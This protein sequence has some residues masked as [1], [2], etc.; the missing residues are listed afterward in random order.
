MAPVTQV[1]SILKPTLPLSPLKDIP[2]HRPRTQLRGKP[3]SA[4]PQPVSI[5]QPPP[6]QPLSQPAA[7]VP[8]RTEEEQQKRA[9]VLA[10]RAARRQSLGNRRVSFAPEATLHTW[11][12]VDYYRGDGESTTGSSTPASNRRSSN[13]SSIA[14]TP[15][16]PTPTPAERDAALSDEEE[17]GLPE[18]PQN[19][20]KK[21]RRA[22]KTPPMNFNNPDDKFMS[23]SPIS[24]PGEG[25]DSAFDEQDGDSGSN[26]DS[27]D[28]DEDA[29]AG[30]RSFVSA[31]ETTMGERDMTLSRMEMDMSDEDETS[32]TNIQPMFKKPMQWR[33]EGE[34]TEAVS[35]P[36]AALEPEISEPVENND[37]EEEMTMDVTRAVGGLISASDPPQ[38]SF[39]PKTPQ[40]DDDD[41]ELTMEM[42]RPLGGL[43]TNRPPPQLQQYEDDDSMDFTR[44]VGGI[45]NNVMNVQRKQEPEESEEMEEMDMTMDMDVTRP[46]GGILSNFANKI[47]QSVGFGMPQRQPQKQRHEE[48]DADMTMDMDITRAIGGIV[49]GQN[50]PQP[51][52][53]TPSTT[54]EHD[55]NEDMTMEFTSVLGGI[56]SQGQDRNGGSGLL[57][58]RDNWGREQAQKQSE[59]DQQ[60][61]EEMDMDMTM[62]VGGILSGTRQEAPESVA[63]LTLQ[64]AASEPEAVSYP[65]LHV[66]EEKTAVKEMGDE[67]PMDMIVNFGQ[68]L[69]ERPVATVEPTGAPMLEAAAP[70]EVKEEVKRDVALVKSEVP[71]PKVKR[72]ARRSS[73][74]SAT[75]TPRV[76]RGA[77][78]KSL[79]IQQKQ[80]VSESTTIK[81]P[82]QQP[83]PPAPAPVEDKTPE[84]K[85]PNPPKR[86][87]RS[88]A[89]PKAKPA[90]PKSK[91]PTPKA[92]ST[93]PKA[94]EVLAKAKAETPKEPAPKPSSAHVLETPHPSEQF[95]PIVLAGNLKPP[96]FQTPTPKTKVH[97]AT[98]STPKRAT[99]SSV[100]DIKTP[101]RGIGLDK[102]GFGSPAIAS[103][104]SGRKP[105]NQDAMQFSPVA[106]PSALFAAARLDTENRERVVNEQKRRR[107][108]EEKSMDLRSR[109]Q[110]LTPRKQGGR[111]SLAL[112][113][114]IPGKRPLESALESVSKRRK[115]M[116]GAS[117]IVEVAD[118]PRPTRK[119]GVSRPFAPLPS[120]AKKTP[121]KTS[122]RTPKASTPVKSPVQQP[123]EAHTASPPVA[124]PADS[125]PLARIA[126]SFGEEAGEPMEQD[127]EDTGQFTISLQDFLQ[128]IDISFLEL[129]ATKRHHTAFISS[130]NAD[131]KESTLAERIK[132]NVCTAPMLELFMHSCR[133]LEKHIA[134]GR[135]LIEQIEEMTRGETPLLFKEYLD[136]PADVKQV[137]DA[138]F[139]NVKTNARLQAKREWYS[140]RKMLLDGVEKPLKEKLSGLLDDERIVEEYKT[141]LGPLLP[142]IKQ[143]WEKAKD[144]LQKLEE[145][146][147][148]IDM[149]DQD[150]LMA[151]RSELRSITGKIESARAQTLKKRQQTEKINVDIEAKEVK[152]AELIASI[153]EAERIKE[154]NRGWSENEVRTWK[155]RCE[156][157]ERSSGWSISC[158]LPDGRLEMLF[159]REVKLI[160][161]P[162]GKAAP[163]V[164]YVPP[165]SQRPSDCRPMAALETEF[166]ISGLNGVLSKERN[167]K[168]I[169]Q[170]IGSYWKDAQEI[171]IN[172]RRLRLQHHTQVR[173]ADDGNLHVR[174][175]ILVQEL[176][177][178]ME[179]WFVVGK[180][181]L[182]SQGAGVRVVYGAISQQ[183]VQDTLS[184]WSG[185]W[186]EGVSEVVERCLEG[187]RRGGVSLG[188]KG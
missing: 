129:T 175:T 73:G 181:S 27:T 80:P 31:G 90:T 81:T 121:R 39:S 19:A 58:S 103:K 62:A 78:R 48:D 33:F 113:S 30:D 108:E 64:K 156:E 168:A 127:E 8:L 139:K 135:G 24:S 110:L 114:L 76:T 154:M 165:V 21:N 66:I 79:E 65:S 6:P 123:Q 115:S 146:K 148:R 106:L 96:I 32:I 18:T 130:D 50:Q 164:E 157:I 104:L 180:E 71:A 171:D 52:S 57:V 145:M 20:T 98:F 42:T 126:V 94:K 87:P 89:T 159:M 155:A 5:F 68:I 120:N 74:V 138:Q 101:M 37:E 54:S 63:Y 158:V 167:P 137:M 142:E 38:F 133:E 11:D 184:K 173:I 109:I 70:E 162:E 51:P 1:K 143:S 161:D 2:A 34:P 75:T 56:L 172:I 134:E 85:L 29:T 22:L 40:R 112:G 12:V 60:Q 28:S 41:G 117:S 125:S 182:A 53:P 47:R 102:P 93:T 119:A 95:T 151:T 178:K 163:E 9:Q 176:R 174:A 77:H 35:S 84:Q 140:W 136:A 169:L 72:A 152:K 100:L 36:P 107:E 97:G 170:I 88:Q 61:D 59:V 44:P 177:S 15:A 43:L 25:E 83:Q 10:A 99:T 131:D 147:R 116:D 144:Q 91:K 153:E 141:A 67:A 105:I 187:R 160:C 111:M 166:F 150:H 122:Q 185:E 86:T 45:L 188:V 179:V 26:S 4:A 124:T 69:Q 46:I 16:T 17:T 132:A 183:A 128:A 92:K 23:S 186:K 149:D 7:T 49:S 14:D 118:E 55:M 13:G 82:E 3:P